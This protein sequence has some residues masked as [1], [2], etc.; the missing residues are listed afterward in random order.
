MAENR[1]GPDVGPDEDFDMYQKD[2]LGQRTNRLQE[3]TP[4][5]VRGDEKHEAAQRRARN[6]DGWHN[7]LLEEARSCLV[8]AFSDL[9]LDQLFTWEIGVRRNSTGVTFAIEEPE[10]FNKDKKEKTQVKIS[11]GRYTKV[12]PIPVLSQNKI[13]FDVVET[14]SGPRYNHETTL[15]PHYS[16]VE[17]QREA[18]DD[19]YEASAQRGGYLL[20]WDVSKK[21]GASKFVSSQL[22]ELQLD[23]EL[24]QLDSEENRS[25]KRSARRSDMT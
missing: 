12:T 19:K 22:T 18:F 7:E 15:L 14:N 6:L 25:N 21:S 5:R 24:R 8:Q 20:T 23:E 3:W 4:P 9:N 1:R 16:S 13:I 10:N 2:R 11:I 17:A